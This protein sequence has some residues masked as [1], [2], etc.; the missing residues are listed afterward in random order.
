MTV[1]SSV[2][3]LEFTGERM[4]P[5][6]ADAVNF[7]EHIYRYRFAATFVHN[8]RVL[9]IACGEGYGTAALLTAG[10]SNVVGVDICPAACEHAHRKYGIDARVGSVNQIPLPDQSIDVVVSFETIEHVE[11]PVG[12]LDECLRVLAPGGLLIISTPNA[13][14]HREAGVDNEFHV[15]E[16]TQPELTALL[17]SR[18]SDW[19]LYTQRPYSAAW[20]SIRS[21]SATNPIWLQIRGG[22]RLFHKIRAAARSM[23][24][25][26]IQGEV[27]EEYRKQPVATVLAKE[28]GFASLVNP[29]AVRKEA[30]RSRERAWYTVA[31]A[32]V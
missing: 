16:L 15:G 3:V 21:L 32:R 26:H 17:A 13:D 4:V 6:E 30:P 28:R 25:P 31:V 29:Y 18:F 11:D 14:V 2:E 20:W 1:E 7:W 22:W 5:E 8:K 12:F 10:A 23:I 19:E 27:G 9:D 24:C